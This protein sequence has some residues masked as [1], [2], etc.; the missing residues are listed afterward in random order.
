MLNFMSIVDIEFNG[1]T[2]F[3]GCHCLYSVAVESQLKLD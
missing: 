3:N 2:V 1:L